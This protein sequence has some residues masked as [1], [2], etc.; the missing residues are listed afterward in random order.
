M[1]MTPQ[2][3]TTEYRSWCHMKTRCYNSAIE[4]Y[5]NYGGRG[6]KV[7][8]RWRNSFT[9]F[10]ADMG[11]KPS[12]KHSLDREDNHGNYEPGNCKWST[13]AE[14][15]NNRRNNQYITAFGQTKNIAQWS[16]DLDIDIRNISRRLQ[17]GYPPEDCLSQKPFKSGTKP[18]SRGRLITAFGKT[19][20][21]VGWAKE[22]GKPV[23]TI[24]QRIS[25]GYS[26]ELCV[27]PTDLT[28]GDRPASSELIATDLILDVVGVLG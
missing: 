10:L 24:Y 27:K 18:L 6:I 17:K 25:L 13:R 11:P 20:T 12:P 16:R 2:S 8:D 7:C 14:Q 22:I 26:P 21:V 1:S 3:E 5:P 23:G 28:L 19:N 9:N 4:A 15:S